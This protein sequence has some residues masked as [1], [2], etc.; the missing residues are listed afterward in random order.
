MG[1]IG[2]RHRPE[3]RV[4]RILQDVGFAGG[5]HLHRRRGDDLHEVVDNDVAQGAHGVVEV[6]AVLDAE[7]LGH[8]DDQRIALLRA[9]HGQAYAGIAACRLDNRLPGLELA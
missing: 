8:R 6:A 3:H 2:A 5:G 7:A 4:E 9:H 1:G